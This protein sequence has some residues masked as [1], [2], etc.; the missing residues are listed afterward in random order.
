MACIDLFPFRSG[1]GTISR[2]ALVRV[3]RQIPVAQGIAPVRSPEDDLQ[4]DLVRKVERLY[5]T[6]TQIRS[7]R[8]T[9]SADPVKLRHSK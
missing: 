1:Y 8:I 6:K 5:E 4:T 7:D 3:C 9:G 2:W